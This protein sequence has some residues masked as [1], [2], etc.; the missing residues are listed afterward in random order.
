MT[1]APSALILIADDT[2]DNREMYAE[3]LAFLG[4]GVVTADNGVTALSLAQSRRPDLV[5][6][7]LSMPDMDGWEAS[8]RLKAD[9]GL[10][11]IPILVV[12]GHALDGS[13][14]AALAAGGDAFLTKPCLP[15]QLAVKVEDMLRARASG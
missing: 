5:I 2:A 12:T 1:A 10:A 8:R 13:E 6:M 9:P 3:Y 11:M 14:R 7:D 4:Y 15:E